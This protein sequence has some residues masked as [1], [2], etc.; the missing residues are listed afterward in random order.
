MCN[1][2]HEEGG[3]NYLQNLINDCLCLF[4]ID[5]KRIKNVQEKIS[6][7]IEMQDSKHLMNYTIQIDN[8]NNEFG[9]DVERYTLTHR[10]L[11]I[12]YKNEELDNN[13]D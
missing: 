11:L 6:K 9:F 12:L 2:E 7:D 3:L 4:N 10:S 5:E 8:R 13:L 1:D